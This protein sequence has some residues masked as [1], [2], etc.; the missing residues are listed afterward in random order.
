MSGKANDFNGRPKNND[1]Q[2][3]G[4]WGR[5]IDTQIRDSFRT[6]WKKS[7]T[8]SGQGPWTPSLI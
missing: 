1:W 8:L 5:G 4:V 6:E 7:S 3:V 2:S